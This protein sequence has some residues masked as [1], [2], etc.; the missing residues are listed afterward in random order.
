RLHPCDSPN[1]TGHVREHRLLRDQRLDCLINKFE[2]LLS[3]SRPYVSGVDQPAVLVIPQHKR[4]KQLALPQNVPADHEILLAG[5][6]DLYP[7][8]AALWLVLA[9]GLFGDDA[10]E[11]LL[12]DS[13]EQFLASAHE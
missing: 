6:F 7:A 10:F 3:E 2:R 1:F 11:P 13:V 12:P 4:A 8:R 5:D 9:L